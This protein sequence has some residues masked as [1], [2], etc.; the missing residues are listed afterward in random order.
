VNCNGNGWV[1][2]AECAAQV[3]LWDMSLE[4]DAEAEAEMAAEGIP[5]QCLCACLRLGFRV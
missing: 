2:T 5:V 1:V 4:R 3:T